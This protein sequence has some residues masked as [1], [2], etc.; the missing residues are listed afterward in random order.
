MMRST[1]KKLVVLVVALAI[2]AI[3]MIGTWMMWNAVRHENIDNDLFM[4]ALA[5]LML[6]IT[7][8]I[9]IQQ[10]LKVITQNTKANAKSV[11]KS[12]IETTGKMLAFQQKEVGQQA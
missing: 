12:L 5:F 11:A 6:A 10:M 2:L 8:W 7:C 3:G 4:R 9:P 1:V